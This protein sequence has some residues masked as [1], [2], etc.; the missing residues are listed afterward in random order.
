[1]EVRESPL[2]IGGLL[3]T[4]VI[5][6]YHNSIIN[7]TIRRWLNYH[8]YLQFSSLALSQQWVLPIAESSIA[9]STR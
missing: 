2:V 7:S 1:M 4:L 9:P 5:R 6:T 8:T 3:A